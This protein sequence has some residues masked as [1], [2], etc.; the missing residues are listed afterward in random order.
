LALRTADACPERTALRIVAA[1]GREGG[2]VKYS[3]LRDGALAAAAFLHDIGVVEGSIVMTA[4]ANME[5]S[6]AVSLG[7]ARLGAVWAPSD[8]DLA[9]EQTLRLVSIYEPV[10]AFLAKERVEAAAAYV[11]RTSLEGTRVLE[12]PSWQALLVQ[13]VGLRLPIEK[14]V[15]DEATAMMLL[16]SGTTGLPKSIMTTNFTLRSLLQ[17]QCL[18]NSPMETTMAEEDSIVYFG[19]PAWISYSLIFLK[20]VCSQSTLVLGQGYTKDLYFDTVLRHRPSFLFFWPE[21]V[22]DFVVLP[23]EHQRCIADFATGLLYAGA[24]TPR[25][26]LLK[27]IQALPKTSI[28]QAYGSSEAVK[29]ASLTPEDHAAVLHKAN[30]A[31][32]LRRLASAGKCIGKVRVV[33]EEDRP[34]PAGTTGRIQVLPDPT[35]TFQAYYKNAQATAAKFTTDGWLIVGDL[36]RM[37]E[38]GYLY[39]EGRDSE[40]IVLLSGDNVYPSEIESA[41]AELPGVV[42]VAVA[43]VVAGDEAI[44]EV[45]AF[46]RIQAEADLS[47]QDVRD[48]FCKRLGQPWSHPTHI[49]IQTEKLPRN[50]N[51]KCLTS[52]LTARASAI[53]QG[54]SGAVSGFGGA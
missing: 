13:A 33:D 7:V 20:A 52:E 37:D 22:V 35:S 23:E 12:L 4:V 54:Q 10:V 40:T 27:L 43:K 25:S 41:I 49:F 38:D 14:P 26:A 11:Q 16:T 17:W 31:V 1:D 36:G 30:D 32:A 42:E 50:R 53:L 6:V 47:I 51:G 15:E 2:P 19:S 48:Q 18:N 45:G 28:T 46:V 34:V 44:S 5:A 39:I 3:E 21:V 9:L 24:R 8:A 29:L